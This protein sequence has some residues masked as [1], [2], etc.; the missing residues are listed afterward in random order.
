MLSY[1]ITPKIKM[2]RIERV[3]AVGLPHHITQRG[4]RRQKTFFCDEENALYIE[5]RAE[6]CARWRV[7]V[8]AYCFMSNHLH[9]I[10]VPESGDGLCRAI[11]EAHCWNTRHINFREEWRD[12][13][14]QG[15]FASCPMDEHY[16]LATA[17]YVELIL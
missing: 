10:V 3:I 8:W 12:H 17:L 4:N 5:L 15:R 1:S 7:K 11:G 6:W 16:L 2:T 14:W 9:L 13:L